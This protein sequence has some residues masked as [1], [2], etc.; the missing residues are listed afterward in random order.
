MVVVTRSGRLTRYM[1][2][3]FRLNVSLV[4]AGNALRRLLQPV[5]A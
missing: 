2:L 4:P 1:V 5:L 3:P